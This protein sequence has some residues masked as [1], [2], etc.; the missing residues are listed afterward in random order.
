MGYF[1]HMSWLTLFA[2]SS[3]RWV[4]C[5][6]YGLEPGI[7]SAPLAHLRLMQDRAHCAHK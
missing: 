1:P 7:Y 2:S 3:M 5:A 4:Q 6:I